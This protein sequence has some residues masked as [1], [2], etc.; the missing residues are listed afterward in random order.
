M[1]CDLRVGEFVVARQFS[2]IVEVYA[3]GCHFEPFGCGSRCGVYVEEIEVGC[4]G[5]F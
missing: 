5:D 2:K 4:G 3:D 1:K